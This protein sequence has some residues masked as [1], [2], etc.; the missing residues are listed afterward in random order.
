[1]MVVMS[2][3]NTEGGLRRCE[4]SQQT[5][6]IANQSGSFG[7]CFSNAACEWQTQASIWPKDICAVKWA[8]GDLI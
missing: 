7:V 6:I 3:M 1:M 8:L 2:Q 5:S 4:R